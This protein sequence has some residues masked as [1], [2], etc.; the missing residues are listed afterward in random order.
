MKKKKGEINK[1]LKAVYFT[2]FI[3]LVS[4]SLF[5]LAFYLFYKKTYKHPEILSSQTRISNEILF[6]KEFL[7]ANPYYI[8]GWIE[9]A[10]IEYKLG[11]RKEAKKYILRAKEIDPN[12]SILKETVKE[13]WL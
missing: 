9:L 4:L 1:N 6:W 8:E 5:N 12:S 13:L 2:I 3:S 10:R 11:N 7:K